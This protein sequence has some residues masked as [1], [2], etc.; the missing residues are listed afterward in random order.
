V[1]AGELETLVHMRSD[2]VTLWT[3]GGGK[4]AGAATRPVHGA[5]SV[6]RFIFGSMRFHPE[7]VEVEM[8]QANGEPAI[9]FRAGGVPVVFIGMTITD[10]AICELRIIGNPDKLRSLPH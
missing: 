9:I 10:Q 8:T 4:A 6:A 5:R 3:D 2:D 1:R 7:P